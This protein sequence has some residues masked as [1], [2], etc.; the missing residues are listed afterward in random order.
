[1]I[2]PWLKGFID[3][4]MSPITWA[5]ILFNVLVYLNLTAAEDSRFSRDLLKSEQLILTGRLFYQFENRQPEKPLLS[6]SQWIILGAEALRNKNFMIASQSASLTGDQ[7]E[8]GRWRKMIKEYL[9][10]SS[11]KSAQIY[12]LQ[13][14]ESSWRTLL[15]YQFM[16][17]SWM[18]LIGNMMML[19]I[20]GAALETSLGG[21]FLFFIYILG[22]IFAAESFLLMS[23]SSLAPMIGASGSLSAVMAFYA[24]YEK[25]KRVS[26][27]YIISPV[28]N[29]WGWIYLPTAMIFPLCFLPDLVGWLSAPD[30]LGSGVAYTAHIGGMLFGA[31]LGFA[32]KYYRSTPAVKGWLKQ[33]SRF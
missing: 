30:E 10:Q 17:A 5:F 32:L 7:I 28:K 27:F 16:H 1:M 9:D 19:I 22:G 14:Q 33:V 11:Q 29:Y 21:M 6:S 15:T 23:K 13:S 18:H 24:A 3:P 4:R 26:F 31:S 2:L 12:G 20:F 25:K 8:I